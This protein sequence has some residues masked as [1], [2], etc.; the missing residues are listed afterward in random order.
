MQVQVGTFEERIALRDLWRQPI[1]SFSYPV[2]HVA[3]P[4]LI[5]IEPLPGP[6][7]AHLTIPGSKSITNRALILAAISRG[8][9]ILRGALWSEDT[10]VMTE[11][12]IQLG[13]VVEVR[14]DESESANR[15]IRVEG[16]GGIIPRA[17]TADAPLEL[18]VANAGTAARFLAAFVCLGNGH[19]RL[20]GVP[21]MHERPQAALFDALQ[22]LGYSITS[23]NHRLPATIHGTGPAPGRRARVRIDESSQFAS[24]L[25]LVAP[26]AG[27][28]ISV[29]GRGDADE[30]PYVAM[31]ERLV[32]GFPTDGGEFHVEPD[33]SSASYF[34]AAGWLCNEG[35]AESPI[36]IAQWPDSG[37]QVDSR[38]PDFLP[39][40]S[41]VSRESDLGDSILTAMVVAAASGNTHPVEFTQLGRLRLQE[42]ERVAAMRTELSRCGARVIEEGDTLRIFPGRLHGAVLETHHDHRMAMCWATLG[43]KVPGIQIRDPGC[44][45]KTFPNFFQKLAAPRPHGLGATLWECHSTTGERLRR[46]TEASDLL[47]T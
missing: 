16:L 13:F 14:M 2:F 24:A 18:A 4:S 17:G 26:T 45:R 8:T 40:P 5:E 47:A 3:I 35:R 12:L 38:F 15:T 44:V 30:A 27:W 32:A 1:A 46:L 25:L 41:V 29:D 43:L 33:A 42:C 19:Y 20:S 34:W 39:L 9:T 23:P 21:R 22:Q 36:Q 31:T 28:S 37:W 11:A 10:Q 6:L 7:T